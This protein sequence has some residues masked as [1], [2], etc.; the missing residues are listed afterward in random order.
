VLFEQRLREGLVD[1]SIRLAF[2]RWKRSQVVAGHQYR[3]GGGA[4]LALVESVDDLRRGPADAA[5][6]RISLR[7]VGTT[8]P[9]DILAQDDDVGPE[10]FD[11]ISRRLDRLDA[12]G[13]DAQPIRLPILGAY[14]D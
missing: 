8:D 6:Y 2:R 1:G 4:G 7:A 14:S 10:E 9:R 11:E 3:M 12:S 13:L 5:V